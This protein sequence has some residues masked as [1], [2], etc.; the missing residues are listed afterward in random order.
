MTDI[1]L[2]V[3]S[4]RIEPCYFCSAPCYPGHGIAFVRNDG[5]VDRLAL[6]C[7][8]LELARMCSLFAG[9]QQFR[10]C[11]SKCHK[12]F[13]VKRNPRK[14]RWTKAF[15]KAAGKEM[16]QAR[17]SAASSAPSLLPPGLGRCVARCRNRFGGECWAAS[18]RRS[19]F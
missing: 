1:Q 10:F 15:R 9:L 7:L 14:T 17:P 8:F 16:A 5:K 4:M 3:C 6:A 19:I 18:S 2:N 13:K 12:A 11:R